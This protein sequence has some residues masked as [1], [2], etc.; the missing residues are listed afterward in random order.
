MSIPRYIPTRVS[1]DP[2]AP[3]HYQ[4]AGWLV[5]DTQRPISS[6]LFVNTRQEAK[7]IC[8]TR[9]AERMASQ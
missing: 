6:H 9:N 4:R 2:R 3:K 8:A 1:K 7:S 5:F